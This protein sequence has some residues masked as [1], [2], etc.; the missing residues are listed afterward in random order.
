M[1]YIDLAATHDQ[2]I[3]EQ[4]ERILAAFK[5]DVTAELSGSQIAPLVGLKPG[6]LYP[7]LLRMHR[8]GWLSQRWEEIEPS[9]A[10]RPRRRLY[11]LTG[12]GEAVADQ[13]AAEAERRRLQR[14]RRRLRP[15]PSGGVAPA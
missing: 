1:P 4:S 7:A 9:E 3:T 10:G 8:L 6:T 12:A 13:V 11:R 14:A 15:S 5:H 2:K